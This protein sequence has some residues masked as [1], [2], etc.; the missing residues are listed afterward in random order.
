M[1]TAVGDQVGR[2]RPL[3]HCWWL[4][5]CMSPCAPCRQSLQFPTAF[6]VRTLSLPA[7]FRFT[8]TDLVH[9]TVD[10]AVRSCLRS[11]YMINTMFRLRV[12]TAAL[13]YRKPAPGQESLLS[14]I[15][16]AFRDEMLV[17][18]QVQQG[19]WQRHCCRE[20]RECPPR[21]G[22]CRAS[23]WWCPCKRCSALWW[24]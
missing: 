4:G 3:Q 22:C 21:L 1:K 11:H 17:P 15:Q 20:G 2:R 12:L 16:T 10:V 7:W 18:V 19:T 23:R 5:R 24:G 6:Q 9:L 8:P 14:W 13:W